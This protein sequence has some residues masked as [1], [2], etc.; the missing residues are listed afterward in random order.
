MVVDHKRARQADSYISRLEWRLVVYPKRQLT[1]AP[2]SAVPFFD[3]RVAM[4]M[5]YKNDILAASSPALLQFQN[6]HHFFQALNR[7]F[8]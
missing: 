2:S 3:D 1:I 8:E 5:E 6:S 7:A 4:I